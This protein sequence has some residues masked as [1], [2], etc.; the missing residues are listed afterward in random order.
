MENVKVVNTPFEMIVLGSG[1]AIPH[2]NRFG[3]GYALRINERYLLFDPSA[4]T[5][6][7]AVK[8]GIKFEEIS[9]IFFSHLHPDH[10]GDLV[11]ILFALKN[12]DDEPT[13]YIQ[14]IGPPG[15]K[16]FFDHLREVYG[17]WINVTQEKAVIAEIPAGGLNNQEWNLRWEPVLHFGNS[18]GYRVTH[19]ESGKVWAYSGDT[20]YCEGVIKLVYDADVAVLECSFPDQFKEIGHLTPSLAGR[21]ASEGKVHHLMLS[22]FY[23][24][25]DGEDMIA[26]C[27][28]EYSGNITAAIDYL[29]IQ[30]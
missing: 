5:L 24:K 16:D 10:T 2:K 11:P 8:C 30:I 22:H 12:L 25:C 20:D 6:H 19:G 27:R 4:G 3:P 7:R 21:I 14:I 29:Q 9:H 13:I 15:F 28:K 23:P 17:N 18:I 26:Q 1:T